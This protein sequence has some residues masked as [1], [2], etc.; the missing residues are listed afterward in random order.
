MLFSL[1]VS[2]GKV[3]ISR[4]LKRLIPPEKNDKKMGGERKRSL[5]FLFTLSIGCCC[6]CCYCCC[7]LSFSFFL[8]YVESFRFQV[9]T[10]LLHEKIVMTHV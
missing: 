5:P 3:L 7:F 8:P 10:L 1:P 2:L 4:P 9:Y 6:C